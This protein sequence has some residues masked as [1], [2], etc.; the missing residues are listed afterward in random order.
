MI[1]VSRHA[2]EQYHRRVTKSGPKSHAADIN[3][4]ATLAHAASQ[5]RR[6]AGKTVYTLNYEGR[7]LTLVIRD[8]YVVTC[9]A[10][11]VQPKATATAHGLDWDAIPAAG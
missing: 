3:A 4:R 2:I 8:G 5:V 11:E 1:P 7:T 10:G 6:E 9:W